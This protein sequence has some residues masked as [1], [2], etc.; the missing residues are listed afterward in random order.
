MI[1]IAGPYWADTEEGINQNIE[2]ARLV[3]ERLALMGIE[4]FCPHMN[5]AGMHKLTTVPAPFWVSLNSTILA[6]CDGI[7]MLNG[8][9][10]SDGSK[11]EK[12]LAERWEL[13]VY[14]EKDIA[15]GKLLKDIERARKIMNIF[16]VPMDDWDP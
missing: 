8:W 6:F 13:P 15:S 14:F 3:A 1:Y 4:Y 10:N 11:Q 5:S 12:D 7:I 2:R 16:G 9:E